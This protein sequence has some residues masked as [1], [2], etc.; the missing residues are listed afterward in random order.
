MKR[1]L[2]FSL[3]TLGALLLPAEE[4]LFADGAG[5]TVRTATPAEFQGRKVL[6]PAMSGWGL[7]LIPRETDWSKFDAVELEIYSARAG[8]DT[9]M[10]SM[11]SPRDDV[12]DSRGYFNCKLPVDWTGWKKITLPF[13]KFTH[14][15]NPQGWQKITAFHMTPKGYGIVPVPGAQIYIGSIRLRPGQAPA[16][17]AKTAAPAAAKPQTA[18]DLQLPKA[19]SPGILFA[20][21]QNGGEWKIARIVE[22]ENAPAVEPQLMGWGASVKPDHPDWSAYDALVFEMYSARP[23]KENFVITANSD[24]AGQSGN[25]YLYRL[26]VTWTGWKTVVLPFKN[27][28]TSRAPIGWQQIDGLYFSTKGY[29]LT[30]QPGGRVY[31]RNIRLRPKKSLDAA[32]LRQVKPFPV[33]PAESVISP[34]WNPAISDFS[35]WKFELT[36][37]KAVQDWSGCNLRFQGK[38][39][40]LRE[41]DFDCSRF[42][43]LIPTLA[44]IP[45]TRI[46]ITAT[47]DQGP[48]TQSYVAPA[49][50]G[51]TTE[52]PLAL[53][54]ARKI[55]QLRITLEHP[56][57]VDAIFKWLLIA[58]SKRLAEME[59]MYRELGQID[60]SRYLKDAEDVLP[61]FKP[62]LGIYCDAATVDKARQHVRDDAAA[63]ERLEKRA[64]AIRRTPPPEETFSAYTT[65]DRRFTRDRDYQRPSPYE[66]AN[67]AWIAVLQ[68]DPE[69]L[70]LAARRAIALAL[71]PHWGAGMLSSMPGT[72]WQ[73]RC[74]DECNAMENLVFALDFCH[75]QF[76]ETGRNLILRRLAES[77][78]GTANFNAWKYDYIYNCNQLAAFSLGRIAT[79]LAMEKAN[80]RHV[81]PYTDLAKQE[82]DESM[83]RILEADGG[84]TE[85]PS[86][87]Q[88]TFWGA[89]P[90]YYLYARG[91]GLPFAAVLP[92]PLQGAPDYLELMFST[93]DAQ[94]VLPVNDGNSGLYAQNVVILSGMFPG[95]IF[96]RMSNKFRKLVGT[97][98]AEDRWCYFAGD[99]QRQVPDPPLRPFVK[100]DSIASAASVREHRGKLLKIAFL[101]DTKATAHKHP[102][103][104]NFLIEYDGETYAMDSGICHYSSPFA[105]VLQ[106]EDRHNVMVP[107][108]G[109]GS[110]LSQNRVG[111]VPK[112]TAEGDAVRFRA[113]ADLTNCWQ[114]KFR[115]RTRLLD[116]PTPEKLTL[117]DRYATAN[118]Q[119]VA[120][121]W[122]APF[123]IEVKGRTVSITGKKGHTLQFTVPENW[124]IKTEKLTRENASEQYRLTLTNPAPQGELRLDIQ[125]R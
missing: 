118:G 14:S 40:L 114:G 88:Y 68:R 74:F 96:D 59:K 49:D 92:K 57:T 47:T 78:A 3:V 44:L 58:D 99:P 123:P 19:Q 34:F 66:I 7:D 41:M 71:H 32:W 28:S 90:A 36:A 81:K 22:F 108:D 11:D 82:L 121:F 20:D 69:L 23:G 103:A 75:D 31:L 77:G 1:T 111:T 95:T 87:Y 89:L 67:V 117:L 4:T 53:A 76:T 124:N 93:D 110:F 61:D 62:G 10:V 113:L 6:A 2:F 83:A 94:G 33:N 42:D 24:P 13:P 5:G 63:R 109:Q 80:W 15:R 70:R 25:Y 115:E 56:E 102:D 73:H 84:Y 50:K 51:R 98:P 37:G 48:R 119:G 27:F 112:L 125:L 55:S 86:Y 91:R 79:Y 101:N 97:I 9:F 100:I 46:E 105:K 52:Y 39:V 104:G 85:G 30:P 106:R 8:K 107:L 43:T 35:Q 12:P 29:G 21:G 16:A 120:F 17:A 18:K 54:G 65:R 26:P 64:D 122:L 116:S 45:G 60:F 38:A 72:E